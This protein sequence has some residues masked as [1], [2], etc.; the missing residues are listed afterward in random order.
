MRDPHILC[1]SNCSLHSLSK[2]RKKNYASSKKLLT[3][4]KEKGP[5]GK[6][7]PFT[8]KE[9]GG[10]VRIRRVAGRQASRPLLIGLKVG[11]TLKKTSGLNKLMSI[12][13]RMSMEFESKFLDSL[14]IKAETLKRNQSVRNVNNTPYT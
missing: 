8:R 7:S 10:S 1:P 13:H 11:R 9:K 2:E 3:S 12:V 5:L 14:R 6:K 4:I